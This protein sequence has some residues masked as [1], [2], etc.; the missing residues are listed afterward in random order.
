MSTKDF[1]K[2]GSKITGE[3]VKEYTGNDVL[4][5]EWYNMTQNQQASQIKFALMYGEKHNLTVEDQYAINL[6]D[7]ISGFSTPYDGLVLNNVKIPENGSMINVNMRVWPKGGLTD[8]KGRIPIYY[9]GYSGGEG[10]RSLYFYSA[11]NPN[12]RNFLPAILITQY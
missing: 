7:F 2:E 10:G 6:N 9:G 11:K 3:D 4:K 8:N 1:I 5:G 12:A